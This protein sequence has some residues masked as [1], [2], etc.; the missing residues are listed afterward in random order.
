LAAKQRFCGRQG[1]IH[2]DADH[3]KPTVVS[4]LKEPLQTGQNVF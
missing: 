1:T 2:A 3:Q 4:L